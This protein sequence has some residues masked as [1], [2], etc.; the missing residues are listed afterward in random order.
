MAKTSGLGQRF[1]FNGFNISGDVGSV[2]VSMTRNLLDGTAINVSAHERILGLASGNIK[3][4]SFFNKAAAAAHLALSPLTTTDIEV[5]YLTGIVAGDPA[6]IM[7]GKQVN[8]DGSRTAD[9]G[10]TLSVEV[11]ASAQSP[12]MEWGRTV[13]PGPVTHASDAENGAT[14]DAGAASGQGGMAQLQAISCDAGTPTY[15]LQDDTAANMATA[16]TYISFGAIAFGDHPATVRKEETDN[17]NRYR[18]V[19]TTGVFT[20]AVHSVAM[21][22]G[23]TWDEATYTG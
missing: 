3:W 16:A 1:F 22:D 13:T 2:D 5:Q 12:G 23:E 8:Y 19:I 9:G 7:T 14:W 11:Q 18:R 20:N 6:I 10:F 21:R 17:C 15:I 4:T